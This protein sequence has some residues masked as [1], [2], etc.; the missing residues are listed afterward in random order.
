MTKKE[1]IESLLSSIEEKTKDEKMID[2][3]SLKKVE[4]MSTLTDFDLR[5][6]F[7][8]LI[9][10]TIFSKNDE[11]EF[12]DLA[13]SYLNLCVS[14]TNEKKALVDKIVEMFRNPQHQLFS[15][16]MQKIE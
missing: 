5:F 9:L 10:D 11:H 13:E 8:Y 16:R 2:A 3:M 15:E 7:Q 14:R 1:T 12:R 4:R 6:S